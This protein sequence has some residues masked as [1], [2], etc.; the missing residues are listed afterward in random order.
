MHTLRKYLLGLFLLALVVIASYL[1]YLKTHPKQLPPNLV[2]GV[3]TILGDEINLNTKYP[4]RIQKI[5]VHD[6]SKV[7]KGQV[8]AIL[9][10]P[11]LQAQKRE[12]QMLIQAKKAEQ[13][14]TEVQREIAQASLPENV[15]KALYAKEAKGFAKAQLQKKID[16]FQQVVIQ[17]K[18]DLLRLQNLF[19]QHLIPKH[20]LEEAQLKL[21][22][23]KNILKALQEQK[24]EVVSALKAAQSTLDQAR[25]DL[26][27]ITMLDYT[28]DALRKSIDSLEAKKMQ[29]E[30]MIDE[31]TLRSPVDGYVTQKIANPGEVLGA[32]MSVVHL[33]D[34]KTLY[35]EIF[36]DTIHTGKIKVGDKAEIFLDAYPNRPIEAYVARIAKKAEFTPKEV[37]V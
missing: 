30:A 7:E 10:S 37:A 26:K 22:K 9:K 28:I 11:E 1:I 36:V 2:M 24:K 29:I 20:K 31:L 21:T 27:K 32:G 23:D 12:I 34:P 15:R 17:D 5:F 25:S 3:G 19:Q 18:K 16:T 8:V 4:G 6:G 35:L 33:I 14:A 13:K